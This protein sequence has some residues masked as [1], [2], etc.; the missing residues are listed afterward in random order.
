MGWLLETVDP[1]SRTLL[2]GLLNSIVPGLI[3]V[4]VTWISLRSATK[5]SAATRHA[6]W[7]VALVALAALPFLPVSTSSENALPSS[8]KPQQRSGAQP[9]QGLLDT[10]TVASTVITPIFRETS[11]TAS[12][13]AAASRPQDTS[14][15]QLV[16]GATAA[17]WAAWLKRSLSGRLPLMIVSIWALIASA[18]V[19]RIV[20]SFVFLMR[21][22]RRLEPLPAS[23]VEAGRELQ[24]HFGIGR[25]VGF[26]ASSLIG[27]PMTIGWARP[28]VILPPELLQR[29]SQVELEGIVAHELGHI[30][31]W[32]YL[33]NLVQQIAQA[34]LFFHP[35]MWV[36]GRSMAIERELA[37]DDWAVNLTGEPRRYAGCL[38][39]VVESL[40]GA[41]PLAMA[42]GI[43][44]RKNILSRRIEMILNRDRNAAVSVSTSALLSA[45]AAA[46][47]VVA[48]SSLVVPAIGVPLR[49]KRSD[50]IASNDSTKDQTAN[51]SFEGAATVARPEVAALIRARLAT[52]SN[53]IVEPI[54][55]G[56]AIDAEPVYELLESSSDND[57]E[58][59]IAPQREPGKNDLYT[60]LYQQDPE[61][62]PAQAPAVRR[63]APAVVE[64]PE[65]AVA[66]QEPAAPRAPIAKRPAHAAGAVVGEGPWD[67]QRTSTPL[68]PEAELITILSDIVK[69]DADPT[70]RSEALRGIYRVRS[71]AGI[72]ALLSL[73]DG[74]ADT[75]TKAEILDNLVRSKGDNS[76]AT[77]KLVQVA[78]T[79]KDETLRSRALRQLGR[80]PGDDGAS[81]LISIYDSLK[82]SKEKQ[83]VIRYL[84]VNK[85]KKAADKLVQIARNDTDPAVRSAAIRA[86]YAIDNRLYLD[87]RD[88][89]SGDFHMTPFALENLNGNLEHFKIANEAFELHQ[90]DIKRAFEDAK[91]LENFKWDGDFHFKMNDETRKLK[92]EAR[93]ELLEKRKEV[94][95]KIR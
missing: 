17:K 1:H 56:E 47:M 88:K 93:K 49:E 55:S 6:V 50:L 21:V 24:G 64:V 15:S 59:F 72:N 86:L 84:G 5:T 95:K 29:L 82:D 35:G 78:R 33:I 58:V 45:A 94:E 10:L 40:R 66:V 60:V 13:P 65:T 7:L 81:Q 41:R 8:V 36:V 85:S 31:R 46:V 2:Q 53:L 25:K 23:L 32:D 20:W 61:P 9:I 51:T 70:V 69:R 18:L 68:I 77:A 3:V 67:D 39:K 38:T 74:I 62:A 43:I 28:L 87:L 16:A 90:E 30:R 37:C 83:L 71:D 52:G 27:M 19:A 44:F 79:E 22:R 89:I 12:A 4:A 42:T 63:R 80:I 73:Y 14:R 75:K 34:L 92:D 54:T 48:L 11:V 57:T 76:R 26:F 91:I